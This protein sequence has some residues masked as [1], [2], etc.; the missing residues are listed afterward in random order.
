MTKSM[1]NG[2]EMQIIQKLK[3]K[4]KKKTESEKKDI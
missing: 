1:L 3:L 2:S 4:K